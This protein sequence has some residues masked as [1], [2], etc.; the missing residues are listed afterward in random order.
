[1]GEELFDVWDWPEVVLDVDT[2]DPK[3]PLFGE[4]LKVPREGCL[5]S[6][7]CDPLLLSVIV[8]TPIRSANGWPNASQSFS[9]RA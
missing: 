1:M 6:S 7:N 3:A 9:T 5:S 4:L 2:D 8:G